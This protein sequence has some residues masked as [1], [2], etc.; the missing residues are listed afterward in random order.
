MVVNITGKTDKTFRKGVMCIIHKQN[1]VL[2]IRK[3][4]RPKD[5]WYFP[6][7]G[8]KEHEIAEE[9]F[10]REMKEEL[11]IEPEDV[12]IEVS[13]IT[14]RYKWGE[15]YRKK[16]GH[17]GQE[18]KVVFAKLKENAQV[19][20]NDEEE[21]AD[22]KFVE[23]EELKSILPF[24]NLQKLLTQMKESETPHNLFKTVK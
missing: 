5:E 12:E 18:Q 24:E 15:E 13:E 2:L 9:T 23:K 17:I 10:Y 19:R 7:G 16:T 21:L 6:A 8:K 11:D 22:F 20:I 4:D 14:H 3:K 1:Q